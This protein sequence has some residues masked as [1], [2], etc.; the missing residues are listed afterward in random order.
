MTT[1]IDIDAV[2]K[3]VGVDWKTA[4]FTREDLRKGVVAER[5]HADVI[6]ESDVAAARVALAHFRERPDYYDGLEVVE[7]SPTGHWRW[8]WIEKYIAGL[9]ILLLLVHV[10]MAGWN[11]V[12]WLTIMLSLLVLLNAAYALVFH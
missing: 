10:Y 7:E 12:G 11:N 8:H 2:G 9:M 5:E 3:A 4:N 6:G 1:N